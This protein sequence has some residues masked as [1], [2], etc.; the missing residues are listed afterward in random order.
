MHEKD[1]IER[2]ASKWRSAPTI[3]R[4]D[5]GKYRFCVDYR[6]LNRVTRRDAFPIPNMDNILDKL[7][8]AKYISKVGLK[9]AYFQILLTQES[10]KYIAF[11]VPGS[12]LW[13]FKRMPF[14]LMN[15]PITFAG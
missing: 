5:A 8:K 15:A 4:K 14:G 6:D 1:I 12:G 7:R 10:K 13:Q 3:V 11:A 2:S 9:Q